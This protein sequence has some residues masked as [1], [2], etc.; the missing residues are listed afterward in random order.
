[1]LAGPH[2]ACRQLVSA[3]V[4]QVLV[5]FARREVRVRHAD[6]GQLL[7]KVALDLDEMYLR[8]R[9]RPLQVLRCYF[10]MTTRW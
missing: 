10:V 9:A 2:R 6:L 5:R 7:M 4:A 8:L 1:V 3:V